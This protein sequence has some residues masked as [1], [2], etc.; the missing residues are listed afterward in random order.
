MRNIVRI[1]LLLASGVMFVLPL[2]IM[3]LGFAFMVLGSAIWAFPAALLLSVIL[4]LV[5]YR[6]ASIARHYDC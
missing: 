3:Y 2:P 6:I 1:A 5:G 4:V